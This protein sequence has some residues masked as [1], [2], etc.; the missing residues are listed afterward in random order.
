MYQSAL[1]FHGLGQDLDHDDFFP[2]DAV[3]D[4][5]DDVL[6]YLRSRPVRFVVLYGSVG[7]GKSTV[8]KRLIIRLNK[9]NEFLVA[10]MNINDPGKLG[11][12]M[13]T[14]KLLRMMGEAPRRSRNSELTGE[15]LKEKVAES[16]RRVL[17]VIDDAQRLRAK[18]LEALKNLMEK[19]ISVLLAAH[20]QLARKLDLA[21][22]EEIGLRTETF[23]VPGVVGDVAGY[24]EF[25]L[26]KSGGSIDSFS[27]EAVDEMSR[28]CKTPRQVR[29]LAWLALKRAPVNNEQ[30]I[31]LKTFQEIFPKDFAHVL[32]ELRRMGYTHREIAEEL[33][34]DPRRIVLGLQGRLPE[35]DDLYRRIGVFLSGLGINFTSNAG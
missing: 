9:S 2:T 3:R 35:N 32:V 28:L 6:A 24:L 17:L 10:E 1:K 31:S 15:I 11:E 13:I 29:K 33:L 34:E 5:E 19:G 26:K 16:G 23:E 18:V 25:L 21:M 22:Y 12:A 8:L 27:S 7:A 4:L 30:Q 14:D 20:T